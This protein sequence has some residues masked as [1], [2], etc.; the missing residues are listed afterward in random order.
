M[1]NQLKSSK[2][3]AYG[4]AVM[5]NSVIILLNNTVHPKFKWVR[6]KEM[7]NPG[8]GGGQSGDGNRKGKKIQVNYIFGQPTFTS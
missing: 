5:I 1:K 7:V 8:G 3:V 4:K 2:V 6:E